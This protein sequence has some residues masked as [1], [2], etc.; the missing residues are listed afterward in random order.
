M[1]RTP[2]LW[3]YLDSHDVAHPDEAVKTLRRAGAVGGL[4]LIESVD[5]RRQSV[6]RVKAACDA[7]R[8]SAVSP[9]LYSFPS[10]GGDIAASIKHYHRCREAT[11]APGQWDVEPTGGVAGGKP[12]HWT[13]RA[14]DE[15]LGADFEGSITTTRSEAPRLNLRGR[16]LWLQLEAQTSVDHLDEALRKWPTSIP[17]IGVFDEPGDRR[18]LDEVRHDLSRCAEQA[19]RV[20]AL[21]VWSAHTTTEEKA[22]VLREWAIGTF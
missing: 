18:T 2:G 14:L 11:G 15:L 20:G 16:E 3:L 19:K 17:V 22:D 8:A 10:V 7:L 21:G 9:I 6:E 5:G 4:V 13:Q 1:T 12:T